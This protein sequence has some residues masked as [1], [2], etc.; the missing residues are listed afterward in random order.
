MDKL[1]LY[2]IKDKNLDIYLISV[3]VKFLFKYNA[4]N[5]KYFKDNK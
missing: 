2:K 3:L 4:R 5:I 1:L